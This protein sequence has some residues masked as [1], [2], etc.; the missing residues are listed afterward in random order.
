MPKALANAQPVI[1]AFPD[2]PASLA[3]KKLA[4]VLS[5]RIKELS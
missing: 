2:A 3:L 4:E 1:T 5:E